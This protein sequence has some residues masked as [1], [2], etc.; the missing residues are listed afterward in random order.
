M[1]NIIQFPTRNKNSLEHSIEHIEEVRRTYCDEV[2]ADAFEAIFSV[3]SSYGLTVKA[4][5]RSVKSIV[6]LEEAVR[7]MVY[8]TKDLEHQFQDLAEAA[9]SLEAE[10][11]EELDRI[12]EETQLHT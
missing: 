12:I 11:K 5:E 8:T 1:D 10:A 9:I 4:N 2:T 3:L 6:F 7:S